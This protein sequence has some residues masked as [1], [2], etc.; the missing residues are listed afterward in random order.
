MASLLDLQD[1]LKNLFSQVGNSPIAKAARPITNF[2]SQLVKNTVNQYAQPLNYVKPTINIAKSV[3]QPLMQR[4]APQAI[5]NFSQNIQKFPLPNIPRFNIG[6]LNPQNTNTPILGQIRGSSLKNTANTIEQN[7]SKF[8]AHP[9]MSKALKEYDK[10]PKALIPASFLYGQTPEGQVNVAANLGGGANDFRKATFYLRSKLDKEAADIMKR[11]AANMEVGGLKQVDPEDVKTV[12][13]ILNDAF[14]VQSLN[15]SPKKM[16]NVTDLVLGKVATMQNRAGLGLGTQSIRENA[17][18]RIK[19]PQQLNKVEEQVPGIRI[20]QPLENVVNTGKVEQ[21]TPLSPQSDKLSQI[22]QQLGKQTI[23]L[24]NATNQAS[25][26]IIAQGKGEIGSLREDKR[27]LREV[28]DELY[29]DWV[30]R[31][32]PIEKTV[33]KVEGLGKQEGF[34]L[35]PEYNPTYQIRKFLGMGGIAEQRFNQQLKPVL[36]KLDDAKIDKSDFDV[37]LKSRRDL[38]LSQRGIM[39]SDTK[40]AGERIAALE[41]KYGSGGLRQIADELYTYQKEGFSDLA[42]AG[43]FDPETTQTILNTNVD[44]VPFQRVMDELDEYLGIPTKKLQQGTSPTQRIKGSDKQ[45]YSPIESIVANTFKQRAAIEKNNVAKSI[46]GLQ[47]AMPELGFVPTAKSGND[48]ITVWENGQK[49]FYQ[50]G[51]EIA[52]SVKGMNEEQMNTIM[53]IASAPARLFRQATTGRNP[54][55]MFPNIL[56]DQVDAAMNAKYGYI[57][58]VDYVRGLGHLL[59]ND[60]M[61]G[62][63]LVQEWMKNGGNQSFDSLSGRKEIK[64][65][66]DEKKAKKNLFTWL[67]K[68]LD[69]LGRYSEVPTRIGLYDRAK[70]ATGNPTIAAFESREG[71]M[72]FSRM[73]AKMSAA[74]S[75][76]PFL[77]VGIQGFDK[78]VRRVKNEP[79]KA[80]LLA[81]IYGVTPSLVTTLYNTTTHPEEYAEIPQYVKD[82]NFVLV[83]GRNEKGTV[84]YI[85]IPKGNYVTYVA[86]PV[87]NFISYIA[88]TNPQ[89]LQEMATQFLSSG[90]P[91]IGDGSTLKEVGLKTVGQLTPQAVKP[92]AENLINKSFFKYDPKKEQSKEI[93]PTYLQSKPPGEQSYEFTPG[94]YKAVGKVLN[95]SPLLVQNFMEGYFS[96]YTKTP[97]QVF[98]TVKRIADGDPVEKNQIPILRRIMQSTYPTSGSAPAV[99]KERVGLF[100]KADAATV[101]PA[102]VVK[103]VDNKGKSKSVDLTPPTPGTGIDSFTNQNWMYS[104][105]RDLYTAPISKEEREQAYTQLGVTGEQVGYDYKATKTNDIKSQYVMSKAKTMSHDDLLDEMIKGREPSVSGAVFASDGVLTALADAGLLSVDEAKALKKIDYDKTGKLKQATGKAKKGKKL[106]IKTATVSPIK[107]APLKLS[108][109]P[110]LKIAKTPTFK[111]SSAK[112]SKPAK[113]KAKSIRI[114][115]SKRPSLPA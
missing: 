74:N 96:G 69:M 62:D 98:E 22:P 14:G 105:A 111:L 65:I 21:I 28:A 68:G 49:V 85:T 52:D 56:R 72:D 90:L 20:A 93:V 36:S 40:A 108:K 27:S 60:A 30:D 32:H 31:Y 19:T 112:K 82:S 102:K 106:T 13:A 66:L 100:G 79:A 64:T 92:L 37:Y 80:A 29:T 59:K 47:K 104:K 67:G 61:G 26:D 63:A 15:W 24:K 71:T 58:G 38:N 57:P 78:L 42:K 11:F 55:F 43:F 73:G 41:S 91:V 50:V 84:D 4:N 3:A 16:K 33:R 48:T 81:G 10:N 46:V 35:R 45:I 114:S 110:K 87:E 53:K 107:V 83:S 1:K 75:I 17:P 18:I 9:F 109:A 23:K 5:Q 101:A 115:T 113:F 77:N 70:K 88:G 89:S 12:G 7:R 76:I 34:E 8:Q 86:N 97:V 54:D 94:A 103:Y 25:E 95:I 6:D 99:N 2:G 39:G 51:Q 44:Y